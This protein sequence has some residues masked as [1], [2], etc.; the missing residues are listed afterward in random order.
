MEVVAITELGEGGATGT[1]LFTGA[2]GVALEPINLLNPPKA[3]PKGL[4]TPPET[5]TAGGLMAGGMSG[6]GLL[7]I[8]NG[9]GSGVG[10]GLGIAGGGGILPNVTAGG[11]GAIGAGWFPETANNPLTFDAGAQVFMPVLVTISLGKR[12]P[13]MANWRK[14]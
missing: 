14:A 6:G 2:L 5:G 9:N 12:N 4:I 10:A 11:L 8:A 3:E 1:G 7:G 13:S